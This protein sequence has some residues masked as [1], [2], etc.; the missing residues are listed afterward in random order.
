MQGIGISVGIDGNGSQ[1]HRL[2]GAHHSDRNLTAVG[3]QHCLD[4]FHPSPS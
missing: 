2:G 4:R 1:P 3:H